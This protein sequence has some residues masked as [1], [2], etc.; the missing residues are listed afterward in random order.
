MTFEQQIK[1][2]EK[3]GKQVWQEFDK[4]DTAIRQEIDQEIERLKAEIETL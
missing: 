1:V 4:H 3:I 2:A